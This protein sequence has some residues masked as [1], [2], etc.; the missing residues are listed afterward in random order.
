MCDG[1][2]ATYGL[3]ESSMRS[4]VGVKSIIS[5]PFWTM[6]PL[7]NT[8]GGSALRV[9]EINSNQKFYDFNRLHFCQK[10]RFLEDDDDRLRKLPSRQGAHKT[11][12]NVVLLHLIVMPGLDEDRLRQH[13]I[14]KSFPLPH[15]DTS[16]HV[17]ICQASMNS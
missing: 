5:E 14:C 2:E 11:S 17:C 6:G 15:K 7:T 4:L 13:S 12:A 3:C 10:S 9:R 1:D 16:S 8:K